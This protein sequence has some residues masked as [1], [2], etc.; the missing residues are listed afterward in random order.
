MSHPSDRSAEVYAEAVRR[1]NAEAKLEVA[2]GLRELAWELK[3]AHFRN[4]HPD[5]PEPEVQ[6]LVRQVF[7]RAL[8]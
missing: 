4:Q 6:E 5:L 1:M 7:L 3:A 2:R 8:R